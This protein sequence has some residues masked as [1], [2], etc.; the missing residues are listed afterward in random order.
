VHAVLRKALRDAVVIDQL[1]VSNP[2]ERSKRPRK[3]PAELGKVWTPTLLRA[4]LETAQ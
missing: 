4:F 2:A 1:L 3:R